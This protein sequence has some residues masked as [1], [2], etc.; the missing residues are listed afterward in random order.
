MLKILK[1]ISYLFLYAFSF[2]VSFLLL[3]S[4]ARPLPVAFRFFM[5]LNGGISELTITLVI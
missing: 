4:G 1:Q 5:V 3:V 2:P